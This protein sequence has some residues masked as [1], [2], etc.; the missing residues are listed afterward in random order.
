VWGR[1][2]AAILSP[3]GAPPQASIPGRQ[4]LRPLTPTGTFDG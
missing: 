2:R 1:V 4:H 3:P